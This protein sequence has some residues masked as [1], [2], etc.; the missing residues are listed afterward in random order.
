LK[1]HFGREVFNLLGAGNATLL[2][3]GYAL[4]VFWLI[5]ILDVST[6]ALH[7]N[8]RE[9]SDRERKKPDHYAGDSGRWPG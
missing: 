6:E 3:G 7:Q 9:A 4:L 8:L 2:S 5:L 1:V